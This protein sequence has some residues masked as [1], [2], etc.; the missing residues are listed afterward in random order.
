MYK[1]IVVCGMRQSGSTVFYNIIRQSYL[2]KGIDVYG[3]VHNRYEEKNRKKVHIRKCHEY[4]EEIKEWGDCF[5][6]TKRDPRD[7]LISSRKKKK[8]C[9]PSTNK[10]M[11]E[12]G[13]KIIKAYEDWVN[14][15]SYA[16]CYEDYKRSPIEVIEEILEVFGLVVG[17]CADEIYEYVERIKTFDRK[18]LK[19]DRYKETLL[20]PKFITN[21]GRVGGY[22]KFMTIKEIEFF[23]NHF[24]NWLNKEGYSV[25]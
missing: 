6:V 18:T 8:G 3:C 24:Q 4:Y 23:N 17:I 12:Y 10:K 19:S 13:S 2:L 7:C 22:K 11:I 21:K 15:S 1:K 16:F 5:V 14:I 20:T 25:E 9:Y